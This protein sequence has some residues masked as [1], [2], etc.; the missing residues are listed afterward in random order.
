MKRK[1][2]T[3][4]ATVFFCAAFTLTSFA[5]GTDVIL[6]ESDWNTIA[7]EVE[8]ENMLE[9]DA[10]PA[11]RTVSIKELEMDFDAGKQV[12]VSLNAP[13]AADEFVGLVVLD[14]D[15]EIV[16][17]ASGTFKD[18]KDFY[19]AAYYDWDM[20]YVVRMYSENAVYETKLQVVY[21]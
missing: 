8:I 13:F 16:Q 19:L 4:V 3:T 15:G 17:S 9:L 7:E 6:T 21:R 18:M 5:K 12:H 1:A 20:T 14:Q 2:T 10:I 11:L